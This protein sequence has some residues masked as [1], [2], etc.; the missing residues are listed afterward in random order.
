MIYKPTFLFVENE[1]QINKITLLQL[2]VPISILSV[3]AVYY[4][5]YVIVIV[6]GTVFL[7]NTVLSENVNDPEALKLTWYL[8]L[9]TFFLI[10]TGILY[11]C[12]ISPLPSPSTS[13]ARTRTFMIPLAPSVLARYQDCNANC[14]ENRD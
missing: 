5:Y 4:Y 11:F 10:K 9:E 2:F 3:A 6:N 14:H 13:T 12:F 8:F 7:H 1:P